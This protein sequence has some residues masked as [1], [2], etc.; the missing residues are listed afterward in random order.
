MVACE[1]AA[2]DDACVGAAVTTVAL[3]TSLVAP[4]VVGASVSTTVVF[5]DA[6]LAVETVLGSVGSKVVGTSG[7]AVL[8]VN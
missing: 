5:P 6:G 3:V 7:A 8:T 2:A 4:A 1:A